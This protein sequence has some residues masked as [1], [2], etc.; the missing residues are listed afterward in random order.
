MAGVFFCFGVGGQFVEQLVHA[1]THAHEIHGQATLQLF[2][3]HP[4]AHQAKGF[5][6][7]RHRRRVALVRR[8]Q[9]VLHGPQHAP[10]LAQHKSPVCRNQLN[11][12]AGLGFGHL[13]GGGME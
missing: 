13:F 3:G 11:D 1:Q 5:G 10:H 9:N 7:R 2:V 4:R 6:R 12:L 8:Q